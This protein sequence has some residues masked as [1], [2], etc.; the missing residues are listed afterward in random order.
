MVVVIFGAA[1]AGKTTI[2][3]ALARELGWKFCDADDFHPQNSIEKMR[4][5]V[6]LTDKDR[7]PWLEKLRELITESLT[8]NEE[9]VLACSALKKKYR[10]RNMSDQVKFVFLRGGREQ[11]A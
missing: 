3:E 7:Q 8:A 9:M 10:D 11:I 4:S 1:G 5:G 2:G 6:P